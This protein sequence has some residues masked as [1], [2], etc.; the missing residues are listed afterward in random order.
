MNNV[1][2]KVPLSVVSEIPLTSENYVVEALTSGTHTTIKEE[3]PMK[4]SRRKGKASVIT[5]DEYKENLIIEKTKNIKKKRAS[6]SCKP[7]ITSDVLLSEPYVLHDL[8]VTNKR[9]QAPKKA[10]TKK[11]KPLKATENEI[12]QANEVELSDQ[13][14]QII[15]TEPTSLQEGIYFVQDDGSLMEIDYLI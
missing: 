5:S 7:I 8:P 3:T 13:P 15:G 4:K 14:L 9:K 12:T 10:A 6:K 1:N 11:C 2:V